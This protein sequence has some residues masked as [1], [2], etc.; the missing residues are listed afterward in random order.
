MSKNQNKL[1]KEPD[2]VYFLKIVLYFMLGSLWL[3]IGGKNGIVLPIGL[4]FGLVFASHDHFKID[5]K[6][7]I[8]ILLIS[9]ILSYVLAIGFV[10]SI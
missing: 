5:R 8:A 10:L 7:E 3:Q 2:S 9:C 4:V 1:K 6:I